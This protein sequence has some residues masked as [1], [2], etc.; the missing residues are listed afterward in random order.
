MNDLTFAIEDSAGGD[1][2]SFVLSQDGWS[3][4]GKKK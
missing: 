2:Y 1:D 3:E 4:A